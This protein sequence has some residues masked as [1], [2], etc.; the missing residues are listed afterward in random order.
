[1]AYLLEVIEAGA[2]VI[3]TGQTDQ[4]LPRARLGE[5]Y[6]TVD[7]QPV[8]LRASPAGDL[9][10]SIVGGALPAGLQLKSNGTVEGTPT[11]S[12]AF[13]FLVLVTDSSNDVHRAPLALVVEE[14]APAPAPEGCSCRATES[15]GGW[16]WL[17]W[18]FILGRPFGFISAFCKGIRRLRVWL[19]ALGRTLMIVAGLMGFSASASAQGQ[20]LNVR[21]VMVDVP[22]E[23]VRPG[24][25]FRVAATIEVTEELTEPLIWRAY[26]SADG[27]LASAIPLGDPAPVIVSPS[28]GRIEA[29]LIAPDARGQF[30]VVVQVD[31]EDRL[32]EIN[33]FDN[34][35][36]SATRIRI[37][38]PQ[39]DLAIA[40]V[41]ATVA[42]VRAGESV[43]VAVDLSNGG[44]AS[45]LT[46]VQ[47]YLSAD[48]IVSDVD[49]EVGSAFTELSAEET[50]RLTLAVNVPAAMTAGAYRWGAIIDPEATVS[51]PVER[52]NLAVGSS[53]IVRQSF[54]T[55]I[56]RPLPAPTLNI[57]YRAQ[58]SAT[59][60]D[61]RILYAVTSGALPLGL[62]LTADGLLEGTPT[63]TGDHT[64][65]VT[66]SS[67]GRTAAFDASL[68]VSATG[69]PLRIIYDQVAPAFRGVR[70]A[71]SLVASGGEPP[72]DW[73][74]V[75]DEDSLPEGLIFSSEGRLFGVPRVFGRFSPQVEVVDRLSHVARTTLAI[76]VSS[77][78]D[79]LIDPTNLSPIIVGEPVDV[80]LSVVGGVPPY[81][82]DAL[83]PAPPGLQFSATGRLVGIPTTVG[84]WPVRVR[85]TDSKRQPGVD[86]AVLRI[87]IEA[88][89]LFEIVTTRLPQGRVRT[90]YEAFIEVDG[91]E[92]PFVWRVVPGTSLPAGFFLT[93]ATMSGRPSMA[94]IFGRGLFPVDQAFAVRV[95]DGAGR[96]REVALVL[97]LSELS[98]DGEAEGCVCVA[99]NRRGSKIGI[100]M[101][102]L[103]TIGWMM[104]R[105]R[106]R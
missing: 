105:S 54:L 59:G 94:R 52:D 71:Q 15:G 57:P 34:V 18:L 100:G 79:L 90:S 101:M 44:D 4:P 98:A 11:E 62:R 61:G 82:W 96:R 81:T 20:S 88:D 9:D 55:F 69:R 36:F 76:E 37:R 103:L 1:N 72:Y 89:G 47:V 65:V 24:A 3:L 64:F 31:A 21:A 68:R 83:T 102:V 17:L 5:P 49:V 60:G 29:T 27:T 91:G 86:D 16:S 70:Y 33:E 13:G 97:S 93:E 78:S 32:D 40:A 50:R 43:V 73:R 28:N 39:A 106:R 14:T 51:E 23:V 8:V 12:G 41:T 30:F 22:S 19:G 66:A 35:A 56:D 48:D 26:L 99:A 85:V 92:P 25:P 58:L 84:T 77:L 87:I 95:E 67:D 10:W 38:P 63:E 7:G 6:R 42:R 46:T 75:S 74:L 45:A 53:I 104:R 2:L 80:P